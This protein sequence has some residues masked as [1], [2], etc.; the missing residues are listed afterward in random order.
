[1]AVP[2]TDNKLV[3][4]EARREMQHGA[5]KAQVEDDINAEIAEQA[6]RAP[7]PGDAR[8]LERV[9]GTLRNR[10]VDEVVGTE[11]EVH[12][13]RGAARV[14]Q[15][16][17]YGFFLLY[18]LLATRLVLALIAA[19][20][21]SGFVQFVTTV[22]SPFYAPFKGIVA[23]PR[24]EDGYTLLVPILVALA[25]YGLLHLAINRL[26]RLFAVRKTEI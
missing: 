4:D 24:T 20:S 19:R 9:A 11:R 15:V 10:A 14:S 17:D 7:A 6:G 13:S 23:S 1:M 25:A 16:I 26:L 21:T 5:V 12:R 3:A 22:T 18:A 2:S 8:K